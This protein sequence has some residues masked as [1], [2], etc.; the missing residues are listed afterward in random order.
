MY[1][2][3]SCQRQ[4][5]K[6]NVRKKNTLLKINIHPSLA[7][8]MIMGKTPDILFVDSPLFASIMNGQL[9]GDAL[10]RFE[11]VPVQLGLLQSAHFRLLCSKAAQDAAH[12]CWSL[13]AER[14]GTILKVKQCQK[15]IKEV[16]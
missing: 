11:R 4:K 10:L 13:C 12:P 15:T 7:R 16:F 9:F 6:F 3:H 2:I 14:D 5:C 8:M 1:I